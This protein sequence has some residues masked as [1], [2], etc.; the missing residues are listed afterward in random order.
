MVFIAKP[1]ASRLEGMFFERG[2]SRRTDYKKKRE[3]QR[4]K[5]RE[6]KSYDQERRQKEET[7]NEG[8]FRERLGGKNFV[9]VTRF[10]ETINNV[11]RC[12]KSPR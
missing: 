4:E 8:R 1:P 12:Q 9:N 7:R 11:E 6:R 2:S 5:G 10:L 3:G